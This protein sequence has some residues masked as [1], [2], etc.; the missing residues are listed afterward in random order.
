MTQTTRP[1][2]T[3]LL[4]DDGTKRYAN[5]GAVN[6]QG[7]RPIKRCGAC[8]GLVVFLKSKRTGRFYLADCFPYASGDAY[9]YV[10]Q[11]PHFKTCERK[12][13][14]RAES[15]RRE[16]NADAGRTFTAIVFAATEHGASGEIA[17]RIADAWLRRFAPDVLDPAKDAG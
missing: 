6:Q 15:A 4:H 16:A 13:A 12:L 1:E 10:A 7:S 3:D 8:G 5:G 11:S 14:D 17:C 2:L 9:Y